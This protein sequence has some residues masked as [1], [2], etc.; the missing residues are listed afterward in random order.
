MPLLA[1]PVLL[2]SMEPL[3]PVGG[4]GM[5]VGMG[6]LRILGGPVV[7]ATYIVVPSD[8]RLL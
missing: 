1:C 7:S 6:K 3:L 8:H 4:P 2:S 5:L